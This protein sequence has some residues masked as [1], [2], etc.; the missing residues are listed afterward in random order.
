[1]TF[2]SVHEILK[3]SLHGKRF[4]ACRFFCAFEAFFAFWPREN[5]ALAQIFVRSMSEEC[6]ERTEKP[7]E[8]LSMQATKSRTIHMKP[9]E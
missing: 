9:T 5:L 8:M 4:C 6:F 3:Y 2:T 1:M 7:A